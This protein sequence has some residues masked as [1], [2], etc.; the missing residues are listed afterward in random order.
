MSA[1][2]SSP[3]ILAVVGDLHTNSFSGLVP[4]VVYRS[5]GS[6][7]LQNEWQEW[8]WDK[9]LKFWAEIEVIKKRTKLPLVTVFNGDSVDKNRH[10]PH[11]L[12][13]LN[14]NVIINTAIE[15][16]EVPLAIADQWY[17]IRGTE[18][19]TGAGAWMEERLAKELSQS[20]YYGK[21][22]RPESRLGTSNTW[23][24]SWWKLYIDIGGVY[25]DIKHHPESTSMRTWTLGGGA[26]RIAKTVV[27]KYYAS[28]DPPPH[29]AIR[30]HYH[31]WEDSGTN[32]PTQA[33][34]L[35]AW[36]GPTD[37]T[38]RR[39][40]DSEAHPVGG[41]Y[42]TCR[43]NRYVPWDR[44]MYAPKRRKAEKVLL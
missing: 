31:H 23:I 8:L 35:P 7:E 28:G 13:D 39:S 9:W 14:P 19:H 32:Q 20:N 29:V 37:F 4:P 43:D 2:E 24:Y 36:Q 18:S 38:H 41:V 22:A 34:M 33:F 25:F 26:M 3:A 44:L 16:L 30:N 40:I 15:V 12:I 42:F 21:G 17:V 11:E 27:D 10:A 1:V 6:R 5:N